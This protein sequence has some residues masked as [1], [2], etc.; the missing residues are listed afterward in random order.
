MKSKLILGTVQMGLD[1]G[2]NNKSGKISLSDSHAILLKAHQTGIQTL[3]T[4]EAYGNAHQVIGSFHKKY[5]NFL[6]KVITKLPASFVT[7]ELEGKI[8]QYALDLHVDKLDCLMFHSYN[9]YKE[10]HDAVEQLAVLKRGGKLVKL[11]VSVYTNQQADDVI[12]DPLIDVIQLP[13]NLFDNNNQRGDVLCRANLAGKEIHS[14]SAFL[15]G[16]FFKDLDK[17]RREYLVDQLY[18]ELQIV[19]RLSLDSPYSVN[20]IAL[21][22]CLQQTNIQCVLIG[23][24]SLQQL[25]SNIEASSITVEKAILQQVD[26]I[27]VK[28]VQLINPAL[29]K[30]F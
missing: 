11:G 27:K 22:Y 25:E 1:Y 17:D 6:F 4:A 16:L 21:Q 19:K 7:S 13:F 30:H 2:V 29:W 5:P 24:D 9:N 18:T 20:T 28:N 14:R 12:Q 26:S 23:V 15:Q 10:H 8:D 3:D